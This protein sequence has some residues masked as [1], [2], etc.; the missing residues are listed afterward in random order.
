MTKKYY[1][2]KKETKG[3]EERQHERWKDWYDRW[4]KKI[5]KGKKKKRQRSRTVSS[6][7]K[8]EMKRNLWSMVKIKGVRLCMSKYQI[9][10][11]KSFCIPSFTLSFLFKSSCD[12]SSWS[13]MPLYRSVQVHENRLILMIDLSLANIKSPT[14]P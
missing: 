14:A 9:R 11:S 1:V 2:R 12:S 5:R 6:P 4:T 13:E 8:E 7:T 10:I 3:L